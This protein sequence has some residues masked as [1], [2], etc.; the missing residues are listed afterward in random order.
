MDS[1]QRAQEQLSSQRLLTKAVNA[2]KVQITSNNMNVETLMSPSPRLFKHGDLNS[3]VDSLK[4]G[5]N[6]DPEY[7]PD[8]ADSRRHVVG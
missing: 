7:T 4:L 2:S 5:A 1:P 8:S 6:E 3:A